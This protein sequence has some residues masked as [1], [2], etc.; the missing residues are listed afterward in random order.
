[1][2]G[3]F[4]SFHHHVIPNAYSDV[5]I[6][7]HHGA[8]ERSRGCSEK[9]QQCWEAWETPGPHQ[10]LLQGHCAL[11]NRH[12]EAR[13]VVITLNVSVSEW[14]TG[15]SNWTEMQFTNGFIF[16]GNGGR[17]WAKVLGL[18][19]LVCALHQIWAC[20]FNNSKEVE[21][22]CLM[23]VFVCTSRLHWWV[24]DHRR[25]QSRENCRQSHRQAEQGK[26]PVLTQL[27]S[28]HFSDKCYLCL[29]VGIDK[30]PVC[31]N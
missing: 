18:L 5:C 8:H 7:R 10:A 3:F 26:V 1:M 12:D 21:I 31:F 28:C 15:S 27:G 4:V 6:C 23:N 22:I 9:H 2:P 20:L 14:R 24:W 16:D 25:P 13:W 30:C 11:P 17:H 19:G 29:W